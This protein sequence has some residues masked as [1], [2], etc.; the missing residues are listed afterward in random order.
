MLPPRPSKNQTQ[1]LTN[2]VLIA[3][4]LLRI[5]VLE[6]LLVQKGIVSELELQQ[7]VQDLSEKIT[8]S[9]LQKSGIQK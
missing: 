6:L 7:V 4:A 9:I 1:Q 5:R 2:D 3:D 8:N